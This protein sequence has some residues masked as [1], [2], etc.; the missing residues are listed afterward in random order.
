MRY[1]LIIFL[2]LCFC[3]Q[4]QAQED[5]VM[6]FKVRKSPPNSVEVRLQLLNTLRVSNSGSLP[7]FYNGLSGL[8]KFFE[9]NVPYAVYEG[10]ERA[11]V[12]FSL[13]RDRQTY[14]VRTDTVNASKPE[15]ALAVRDAMSEMADWSGNCFGVIDQL[16]FN[17]EV[18]FKPWQE[19]SSQTELKQVQKPFPGTIKK[20]HKNFTFK[21]E[22]GFLQYFDNGTHLLIPP[23]AFVDAEG[24]IVSGKIEVSYR[25]F[26]RVRELM[27]N[28]IST[29]R[30]VQGADSSHF[31]IPFSVGGVVEFRAY[32]NDKELQ[33]APEKKVLL[34]TLSSFG[35]LDLEV[36]QW[37]DE[38]NNWELAG[39]EKTGLPYN[40]DTFCLK[41]VKLQKVKYSK[42]D[43][44]LIVEVILLLPKT[45]MPDVRIARGLHW[46]IHPDDIPV[47]KQMLKKKKLPV[48]QK[49]I[50]SFRWLLPERSEDQFAD[51]AIVQDG[52][53]NVKMIFS[54]GFKH[55]EKIIKA[56]PVKKKSYDEVH[57]RRFATFFTR[58][59]YYN[60]QRKMWENSEKYAR[61]AEQK[62]FKTAADRFY[63]TTGTTIPMEYQ[64]SLVRS[65]FVTSTGL[66][67]CANRPPWRSSSAISRNIIQ[68]QN[69][70]VRF[71]DEKYREIKTQGI[72]LAIPS[73]RSV[74]IIDTQ[75]GL[76]PYYNGNNFWGFNFHIFAPVLEKEPVYY[77]QSGSCTPNGFS[78]FDI[79]LRPAEN[80]NII[81]PVAGNE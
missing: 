53:S 14:T 19:K 51:M 64:D 69:L 34:E 78:A 22:D 40:L 20:P 46:K 28:G 37:N 47:V 18:I 79:F 61:F 42:K 30:V 50:L 45:K 54:D 33:L 56:R 5:S 73:S 11:Q 68:A 48:Q 58:Y 10:E 72:Y 52:K 8:E 70:P 44:T 59:H 25:D 57:E 9:A 2:L 75:S 32:K 3:F 31:I 27:A 12:T 71:A 81:F 15:L 43:T 17:M 60:I 35:E 66:F 38:V 16:A 39:R 1:W 4:M 80:G 13:S 26:H 65:F 55:E 74:I 76:F 77:H 49:G 62:N 24:K 21:A 41:R 36:Q 29:G 63:N 23:A 7:Q 67:L 6:V